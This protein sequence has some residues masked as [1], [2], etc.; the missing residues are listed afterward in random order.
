MESTKQQLNYSIHTIELTRHI[1][2]HAASQWKRQLY[3]LT[4]HRHAHAYEN[5][6]N[7]TIFTP[8]VYQGVTITLG[9]TQTRGYLKLNINLNS[10]LYGRPQRTA[11]LF[12]LDE[13]IAALDYN[14]RAILQHAQLGPAPAFTFSRVD[15]SVDTH[16]Q[17]PLAYIQLAHKTGVPRGYQQTY[18]RFDNTR[19]PKQIRYRY[20][21]DL[22]RNDGLWAVTLYSKAHQLEEDR[23]ASDSDRA[24]TIGQL[25]FEVKYQ[26]RQLKNTFHFKQNEPLTYHPLLLKTF[27]HG[28][29]DILRTTL[30]DLFPAGTYC[31]LS[32]AMQRIRGQVRS[33]CNADRL[34]DWIYWASYSQNAHLAKREVFQPLSRSQRHTL[35]CLQQQSD[36]NPVTLGR[37][38]PCSSLPGIRVIFGAQEFTQNITERKQQI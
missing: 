13:H 21:Y 7:E 38:Q 16:V 23:H 32:E 10:L 1:P 19:R 4:V 8:F 28:A 17:H 33:Q 36:V 2:L 26:A 20:S 25:R 14:L 12:P 22:T 6:G 24:H 30:C 18:P 34:C 35:L 9:T 27:L 3:E 29:A 15:F 31:H 5:V 11:L 37:R